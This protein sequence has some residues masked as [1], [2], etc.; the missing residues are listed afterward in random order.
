MS[1]CTLNI[2]MLQHYMYCPRR[3][4]LLELNGDWAE[5]AFVVK[6]NLMHEHVH[7]GSHDYSDIKKVV[8]SAIAVYNDNP[9]YDLY[10]IL[11]CVE[12]L[13]DNHGVEI[14]ELSGKY[15]I[16][17]VEYKPKAPREGS[18]LET[19]AIQ[20][21]AQKLCADYVWKC[22]SEAYLYYSDTRRRVRLPFDAE[23]EKYHCLVLSLLKEMR[24]V[25]ERQEIPSRRKGQKCAGCSIMD[26]CFP[27]EK[28]Y[29]IRDI[30]MSM[31]G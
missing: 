8:R 7:D 21:F 2:R 31:K 19:D 12:F 15:R 17:I 18:F 22:D 5:N 11:D 13:K 27:K 6:A 23:Y 10:G 1:E 4:A 16:R 3:F 20:V 24:S 30:V 14:P 28:E 9:Q 25:L 29:S 26:L